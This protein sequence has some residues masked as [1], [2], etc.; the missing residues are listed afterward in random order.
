MV[1]GIIYADGCIGRFNSLPI[2]IEFHGFGSLSITISIPMPQR[3]SATNTGATAVR[4]LAVASMHGAD[5]AY[6]LEH[7]S[8]R[9]AQ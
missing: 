4:R 2:V 5:F 1:I 7:P 9:P 3:A 6:P 8:P